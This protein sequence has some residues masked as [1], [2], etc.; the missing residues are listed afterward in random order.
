MVVATVY[1]GNALPGVWD[2]LAVVYR[3]IMYGYMPTL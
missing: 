3:C 1:S 2:S